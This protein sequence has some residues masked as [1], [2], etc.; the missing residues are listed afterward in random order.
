MI[1]DKKKKFDRFVKLRV[2]ILISDNIII[3]AKL[4]NTNTEKTEEKEV[5]D[6]NSFIKKKK[7]QNKALKKLLGRLDAFIDNKIEK[8]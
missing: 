7:V 8:Q 4:Q 1:F 3:M 2:K 6:L 5:E